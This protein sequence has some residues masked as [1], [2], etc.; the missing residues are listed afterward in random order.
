MRRLPADVVGPYKG[1]LHPTRVANRD[2]VLAGLRVMQMPRNVSL[3][4]MAL[5]LTATAG[6]IGCQ[7]H[8]ELPGPPI[9]LFQIVPPGAEAGAARS[10]GVMEIY[11]TR[12]NPSRTFWNDLEGRTDPWG[13]IT[14]KDVM[15]DGT[16]VVDFGGREL[17]AKSGRVFPG[18]GI[19][20]IASH[21][22]LNTALLRTRWTHTVL[23][24]GPLNRRPAG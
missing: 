5:T 8:E 22:S 19:K 24:R 3:M 10:R 1:G 23:P 20:V 18:T 2:R 7:Q 15:P 13:T 12:G 16:V 14:L 6:G 4:A 9:N 11:L 21:H 17:R